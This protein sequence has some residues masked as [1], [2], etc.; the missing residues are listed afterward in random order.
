M[1]G[2]TAE[3]PEQVEDAVRSA[4]GFGTLRDPTTVEQ[5]V[6]VGMGGSGMAGDVVA[7]VAA[8]ML[9]VPVLVVKS[10]ECP[11]FVD[12]GS[13][14]FAISASGNTEETLQVASV[15]ATAGATVVVITGGGRLAEAAAAW[16]A[17]VLA[18]PPEIP[19]P[20]A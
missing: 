18:V 17:P 15:A 10:Y 5:V 4:L 9:A 13:L 8:P 3:L 14:V 6:V 1:F 11:A 19:Q 2:A 7:A 16:N 20:R 12:A